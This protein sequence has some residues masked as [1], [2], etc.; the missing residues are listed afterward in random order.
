MGGGQPNASTSAAWASHNLP[1]EPIPRIPN[2]TIVNKGLSSLV[3]SVCGIMRKRMRCGIMRKTTEVWDHEKTTE[4][5]DHGFLADAIMAS[6]VPAGWA[7]LERSAGGSEAPQSEI[8][9]WGTG[10]K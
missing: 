5:W 8:R 4:V 9:K 6:L 1:M 2:S 10:M 3:S 7:R